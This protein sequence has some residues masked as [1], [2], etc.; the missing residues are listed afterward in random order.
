MVS[1][2]SSFWPG[3]PFVQL[4]IHEIFMT[5]LFV[6]NGQ[7]LHATSMMHTR[8]VNF[9]FDVKSGHLYVCVI[10]ISQAVRVENYFLYL[11]VEK[12]S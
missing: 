6:C 7:C 5:S 11:D 1:A 8:V 3:A 12:Y 2:H 9:Y 10:S 4:F